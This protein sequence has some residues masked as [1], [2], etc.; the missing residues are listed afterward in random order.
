MRLLISTDTS[1]IDEPVKIRKVLFSVIP[2]P[3][4]LRDKLQPKSRRFNAFWLPP[5]R[6]AGQAPQVRHDDFETFYETKNI[7][8]H[9]LNHVYPVIMSNIFPSVNYYSFLP[10]I[11]MANFSTQLT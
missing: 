1:N 5:H 6:G 4:L 9:I 11:E 7:G 3:H 8:G 2:A 10:L